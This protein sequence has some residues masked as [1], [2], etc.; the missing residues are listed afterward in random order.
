MKHPDEF[1]LFW[2]AYP[3][4][5]GKKSAQKAWLIAVKTTE[6][7][8]IIQ[9]AIAYSKDPSR[10]EA[11]TAHPT[12]WLNAGRWLDE[13]V[14]PAQPVVLP[15]FDPKEFERPDAVPMPEQVRNVLAQITRKHY[16]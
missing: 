11:Y 8:T 12:T 1:E 2:N 4:K 7:Q 16:D 14:I 9:G 3:K 6:A 10:K 5:V 15:K 13:V